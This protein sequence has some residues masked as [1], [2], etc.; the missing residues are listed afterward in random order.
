MK[1]L[2]DGSNARMGRRMLTALA[3]LSAAGFLLACAPSAPTQQPMD[4]VQPSAD[5]VAA[6]EVIAPASR[7]ATSSVN[8]QDNQWAVPA[9]TGASQM[10]SD[11]PAGGFESFHF[12]PAP[13]TT[14]TQGGITVSAVGSV[15]RSADEAYVVMIPERFYGAYG[16]ERLSKDDRGD[17]VAQLAEIGVPET[18][19]EFDF[20][21]RYGETTISVAVAPSEVAN[22]GDAI[23]EVVETVVRRMEAYGVRFGLDEGNCEG[24]RSD[25]RREAVPAAAATAADLAAT[26]GVER[27]AVTGVLEDGPSSYQGLYVVDTDLG[28]CSGALSS[29][30]S[31]MLPF[32]AQPEV[33]VSVGL[34]VTY[35]ITSVP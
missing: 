34:R 10:S 24:A 35:A 23:L 15:T 32:D 14:P 16:R 31:Q 11:G 17:I 18:A 22:Q 3:L 30:Y 13:Q 8:V 1:H 5:G 2:S 4:A 29:P 21:G 25:A 7:S 33:N 28:A 26:L 27:G 6:P 20:Q 12:S 19:V 9:N